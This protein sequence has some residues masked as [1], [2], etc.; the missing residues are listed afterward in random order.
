MSQESWQE[1]LLSSGN[2]EQVWELFHENS[3]NGRYSQVPSDKEVLARIS[4]FHESL[5]FEGYPAVVLPFPLASLNLSLDEAITFRSS[6]RDLIPCCLSMDKV[7]TIL[8]HSYGIVRRK[9]GTFPRGLRVVPSGGGL[10]PLEI[11]FYTAHMEDQRS[12]VYHYN[13]SKNNLRLLREGDATKQISGSMVQSEIGRSAS[14]IIFITAIFERSIFKYED[15][16]YRY[17]FLEAGHVAQNINLVSTALGLGSVNIGGFFDR[18][19]DAFLDLDGV[20]HSTI[21]MIA[22]GG[23][24]HDVTD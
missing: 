2:Q 11:F 10:Y 6:V 24:A 23:N 20:T 13:P 12:G 17:I 19:I 4:Q 5:S 8:H 21:Y 18:E 16:G 22:I 14:L 15:R 7:A 9:A 1:T 3:K